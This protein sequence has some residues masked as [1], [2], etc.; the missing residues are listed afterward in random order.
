MDC[1]LHACAH[2]TEVKSVAHYTASITLGMLMTNVH[3]KGLGLCHKSG[4]GR[5]LLEAEDTVIGRGHA[6]PVHADA[7]KRVQESRQ[8]ER[9]A[10]CGVQAPPD[11][12]CRSVSALSDDSH[13]ITLCFPIRLVKWGMN[14]VVCRAQPAGCM[15]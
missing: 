12:D 13:V 3:N 10:G 8:E 15:R 5:N 9:R 2:N 14:S 1:L 6:R 7:P 11:L 4:C